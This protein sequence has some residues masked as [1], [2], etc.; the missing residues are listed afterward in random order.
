MCLEGLGSAPM[1]GG[2]KFLLPIRIVRELPDRDKAII[3][4]ERQEP[5]NILTRLRPFGPSVLFGDLRGKFGAAADHEQALTAAHLLQ[6][7]LILRFNRYMAFNAS[8]ESCI[9]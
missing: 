9:F 4:V 2:A 8:A 5:R 3:G 6:F 7:A 1:I